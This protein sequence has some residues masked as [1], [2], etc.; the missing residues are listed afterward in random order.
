MPSFMQSSSS[1]SPSASSYVGCGRMALRSSRG[2]I[3]LAMASESW[4]II[5]VACSHISCAPIIAPVPALATSFIKPL[6]EPAI[7]VLALENRVHLAVLTAIPASFAAAS[8]KPTAAISGLQY[9]QPGTMLMSMPLLLP[10][11]N[12]A[13]AVP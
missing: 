13:Q 4:L 9:T 1:A 10:A 11:M 5:S 6:P 3:A 12:P 8:L 7:I 2:V